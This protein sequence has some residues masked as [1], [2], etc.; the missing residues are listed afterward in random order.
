MPV[1]VQLRLLDQRDSTAK[2][3]FVLFSVHQTAEVDDG[4]SFS[5]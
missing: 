5:F 3:H 1:L 2:V 4:A